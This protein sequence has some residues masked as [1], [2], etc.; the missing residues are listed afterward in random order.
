MKAWQHKQGREQAC[1]CSSMNSRRGQILLVLLSWLSAPMLLLGLPE[2]ELLSP[3]AP[4]PPLEAWPWCCPESFR[5]PQL[6]AM[7][8]AVPALSPGKEQHCCFRSPVL[9]ANTSSTGSRCLC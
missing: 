3:V 2:V 1:E 8:A 6:L 5:M 4:L 9:H 7:A